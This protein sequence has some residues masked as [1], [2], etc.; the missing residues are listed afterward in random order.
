MVVLA[1]KMNP[2][3]TVASVITMTVDLNNASVLW[4]TESNGFQGR[5]VT[6]YQDSIYSLI[7]DGTFPDMRV[8]INIP[9]QQAGTMWFVPVFSG[10]MLGG[11]QLAI[12]DH[13][14]YILTGSDGVYDSK[15][16]VID[17]IDLSYLQGNK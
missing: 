16:T 9:N 3:T 14:L 2:N 8:Q 1:N 11:F 7:D 4:Q 17:L 12:D 5:Y 10:Y 15:I 13:K 6:V